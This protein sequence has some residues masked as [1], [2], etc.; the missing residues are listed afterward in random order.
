[1][2][3]LDKFREVSR[4]LNS[5]GIDDAP[6]EAE[7]LITETLGIS[8]TELYSGRYEITDEESIRVDSLAL[9][10]SKREPLQYI[11]GFVEFLGLRFHLGKGVLIPRQETELLAQ[12]AIRLLKDRK[13][14]NARVLDL[15]TGSG[16]IAIT[17]AR[18]LP[19]TVV[20]AIDISETALKYACEN[21]RLN[22]VK[23]VIFMKGDLYEPLKL[24][25]HKIRF[26]LIAS[27]PPYIRRK[28]I[29]TLQPEIREWEPI[30]ALNGGEDGLDYYRRIIGNSREFLT[31]EGEILLEVGDP[32]GVREIAISRGFKII[33]AIKDLSGFERI[34]RLAS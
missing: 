11:L 20:Y 1:M 13:T 6:R 32:D 17:I 18:N 3:A 34:L 9:R 25:G 15:C 12:E 33:S 29:E 19:D 27:N 28:E 4:L 23:N 24:S 26:D 2:T 22:N 8:K 10:R 31:G 16:C 30:E 21:A 14:G 5:S 7:I